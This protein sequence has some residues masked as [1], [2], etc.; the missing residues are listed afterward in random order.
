MFNQVRLEL[1]PSRR[2]CA[3][4]L[5]PSIFVASL[6][7]AAGVSTVWILALAI[8]SLN[9]W[10]AFETTVRVP[11]NCKISINNKE[12]K[13]FANNE[14]KPARFGEQ[15]WFG[16]HWGLLRLLTE[17]NESVLIFLSPLTV[18]KCEELR[19]LKVHATHNKQFSLKTTEDTL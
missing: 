18:T 14:F 17:R 2:A 5:T 12:L 13:L 9:A 4:L 15:L 6:A 11:R 8:I 19:R 10:Y 1:R 3:L 16:A 7:F